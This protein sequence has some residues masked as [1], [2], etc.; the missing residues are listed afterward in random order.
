MA[1]TGMI[2]CAPENPRVASCP[3]SKRPGTRITIHVMLP[4]NRNVRKSK[5]TEITFNDQDFHHIIFKHE[6]IHRE[7]IQVM[8]KNGSFSMLKKVNI[9]LI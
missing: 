3:K 5:Q 4:T 9:S 2:I 7:E 6:S 1:T 8:K